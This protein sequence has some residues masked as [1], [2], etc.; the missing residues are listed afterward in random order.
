MTM[1]LPVIIVIS[2]PCGYNRRYQLAREFIERSKQNT[3][4]TL[5]IVELTYGDQKFQV[6]NSDCAHHLQLRGVTPLW[7]KENMINLGINKLLPKDW[8]MMA[9]VDCDLEFENVHW[10]RDCVNILNNGKTEVVQLFSHCDDM[11]MNGNT[12]AVHV[13]FG[14]QY[15]NYKPLLMKRPNHGH[16]GYAWAITRKAYD[17]VGGLFDKAI[18]GGGDILMANSIVGRDRTN[19]KLSTAY[20]NVINTFRQNATGLQVGYVT[21]LIRHHYHGSKTSRHY[22]T[23]DNI[24]INHGYD[25]T[26]HLELDSQGLIVPSPTCPQKMLDEIIMYFKSRNEDR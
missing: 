10:G 24:L 18:L 9:W 16:A 17:R 26:S 21:G 8:T 13:S 23:R 4:I 5:Y 1:T 3:D 19:V 12:M 20:N 15:C 2:N 6:T 22:N 7:H 11:D 14:Y 25:P